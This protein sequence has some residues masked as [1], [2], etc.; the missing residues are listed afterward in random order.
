MRRALLLRRYSPKTR[1]TYLHL[2]KD[3]LLFLRKA[4]R[5]LNDRAIEDYL[6]TRQQ[7]NQSPQTINLAL[8]AIKFYLRQVR[9]RKRN[10]DIRHIKKDA[11]LPAVLT[12]REVSQIIAL[13]QNSKYR[14]MPALSYGA[15]L[16]VSEVVGLR[17]ADLALNELTIYIKQAKGRKDRLTV[18]PQ[19]LL[20]ALRNQI[21]GKKADELVFPSNRGTKLS[22]A[23]LQKTFQKSLRKANI[24]KHATFHALRHSFATHL[25]EN[26]TDIR[27]V[28][29]LLGHTNIRTTQIYTHITNPALKNIVSPL[30]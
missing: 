17:V 1:Q 5:P 21:A 26:G 16:R 22:T 9:K 20:G 13:T 12:R 27:Y 2:L 8:Q 25:L 29:V 24:Q 11:R 4:R 6:L 14:L 18:L 10:P 3:F 30:L 19:K 23:T 28:Q 7:K 15:G